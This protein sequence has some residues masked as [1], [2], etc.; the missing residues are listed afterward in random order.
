MVQFGATGIE[1]EEEDKEEI[2]N[3]IYITDKFPIRSYDL[4][5][6]FTKV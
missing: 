1:D 5:F 6:Y 3:N 2:S 4:K